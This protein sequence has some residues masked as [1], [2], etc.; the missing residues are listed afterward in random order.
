MY[1]SGT[2]I[3]I[4]KFWCRVLQNIFLYFYNYIFTKKIVHITKAN[5]DIMIFHFRAIINMV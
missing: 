5:I 1:N 3:R 2:Y 4:K